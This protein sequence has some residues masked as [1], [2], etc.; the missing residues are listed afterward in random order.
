MNDESSNS[1]D[2]ISEKIEN[3]Q[4]NDHIDDEDMMNSDIL[5]QDAIDKK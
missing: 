2:K 1:V 3:E 4:E 5:D